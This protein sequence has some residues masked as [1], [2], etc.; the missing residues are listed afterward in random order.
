[1]MKHTKILIAFTLLL[2][3]G[4]IAK[5][6]SGDRIVVNLPFEFVV[7]GKILPAGTYTASQLSQD[8]LGALR[9]TS[10]ANGTSVFVLP[11][12]VE[13]TS[14]FMPSVSFKQVGGQHFLS[15]IQTADDIYNIPVSRS[16]ILEAAAKPSDTVSVSGS[17]GSN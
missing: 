8:R 14:A 6:E 7:R 4:G 15:A 9:L 5:A 1:M 13:S 11:Y 16:V 3:L 10:R 17:G 2:G 12:E